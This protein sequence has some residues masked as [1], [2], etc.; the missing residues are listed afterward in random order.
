MIA[1]LML[2][3][4]GLLIVSQGIAIDNY[5]DLDP[6][7]MVESIMDDIE[8]EEEKNKEDIEEE[9][10]ELFNESFLQDQLTKLHLWAWLEAKVALS[11]TF[12]EEPDCPPPRFS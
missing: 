5:L 8:E 7:E 11:H 9:E 3:L 4:A 12:V 1:R 10:D 2:I 6:Q